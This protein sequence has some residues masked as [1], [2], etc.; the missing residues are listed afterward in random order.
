MMTYDI[1]FA[2]GDEAVFAKLGNDDTVEIK[3]KLDKIAA[4]KWRSPA[5]W[6]Y[7]PWQSGQ[8]D[9]KYSWGEYRVFADI[10]EDSKTIIVREARHRENL[11]R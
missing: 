8:A 3:K 6:N 9:G 11:Y 7:E 10:D 2:G 5:D 4:N 1:S